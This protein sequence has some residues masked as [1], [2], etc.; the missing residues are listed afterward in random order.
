MIIISK[1]DIQQNIYNRIWPPLCFLGNGI[2]VSP[3]LALL[4]KAK[5]LF[6][7]QAS[8]SNEIS[9]KTG[10]IVTVLKEGI[11]FKT[12]SKELDSY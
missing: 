7:H 8:E 12:Y 6:D 9:L 10:E 2:P 11:Y 3:Y 5:V 1:N 4:P